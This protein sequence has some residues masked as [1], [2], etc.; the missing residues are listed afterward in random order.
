MFRRHRQL[1]DKDTIV[2]AEF[3]NTTGDPV[4]DETLRQGLAI[5]LAQSPFLRL[6]P[7]ERLQAMRLLMGLAADAPLTPQV[8]RA[9]CER[10]GSAAVLEGSISS[11][12]TS[13]VVGLRAKNCRDG[14]VLDEEQVQ[15]ARKEDV[16]SALSRIAVTFRTRVGESLATVEKHSTPLAEATTPSLEALKAYSQALKVLASDGDFAATPLFKRAVAIDPQ[17][18][19]AHARLGLAYFSNGE[20]ILSAESF[21]TARQNRQ[22]A[23]DQERFFIDASYDLLVTGNLERA[24]Q[25]CEEWTR[26]YPRA[27]EV[28]GFLSA[29]VYSV[30]GEYQKALDESEKLLASD[31]DLSDCIPSG[32]IQQRLPRPTRQIG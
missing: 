8:A 1:T 4:F 24:R 19:I 18:A 27:I 14:A 23:S 10:T 15:V 7:D 22:R 30:L 28:H 13:Y 3:S 2:L 16:L 29:M 12:G 11:L 26:T 32:R 5:Q 31:P 21:A 17:F 9:A 25:T 6:I 20:T